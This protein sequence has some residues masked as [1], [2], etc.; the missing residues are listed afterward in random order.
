MT[1]FTIE[2]APAT[3]HET[4][5]REAPLLAGDRFAVAD[6]PGVVTIAFATKAIGL[7]ITG[8]HSATQRGDGSRFPM[9]Q[10]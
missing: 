2:T 7:A 3:G 9:P 4:R 8:G 6:I 5:L 1:S 10:D